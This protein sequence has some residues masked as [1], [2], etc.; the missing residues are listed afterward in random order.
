MLG[1]FYSLAPYSGR[2]DEELDPLFVSTTDFVA[3]IP[4]GEDEDED[5]A[6]EFEALWGYSV[7]E[8]EQDCW[9]YSGHDAWDCRHGRVALGDGDVSPTELVVLDPVTKIGRAHV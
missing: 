5:E 2:V 1:F 9:R 3:C 8:K 4:G 6:D 7:R